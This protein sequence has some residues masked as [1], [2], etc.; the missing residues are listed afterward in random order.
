M[1]KTFPYSPHLLPVCVFSPQNESYTYQV[2]QSIL[3]LIFITHMFPIN[4]RQRGVQQIPRLDPFQLNLFHLLIATIH[5]L[6]LGN[7]KAS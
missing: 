6:A 3:C 7:E 4:L 2:T 5:L 1:V